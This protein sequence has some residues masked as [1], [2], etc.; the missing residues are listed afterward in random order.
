[1]GR[2]VLELLVLVVQ[3]EL[4]VIQVLQAHLVDLME[5]PVPLV[6]ALTVLLVSLVLQVWV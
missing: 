2:L 6:L 1:M 5:Q 3:Q 4:L